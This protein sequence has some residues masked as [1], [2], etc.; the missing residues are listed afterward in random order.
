MTKK[1]LLE[2]LGLGLMLAPVLGG[3]GAP[4]AEL[5]LSE[6]DH[7]SASSVYTSLEP[8]DCKLREDTDEGPFTLHECQGVGDYSLH[9]SDADLRQSV[10][11]RFP[12]GHYD[13]PSNT[14]GGFS[15]VGPKAEWRV[16]SRR[17]PYALIFRHKLTDNDG[18]I[19]GKSRQVLAVTKLDGLGS[20]L[21]RLVDANDGEANVL[22]RRVADE[23]RDKP[24]PG[25]AT[26]TESIY[27]SL[28]AADCKLV[29]EGDEPAF[30]IQRCKGLA[31]Y[32]LVVEDFDARQSVTVVAPDGEV[33]LDLAASVGGGFSEVGTKAE[34]RRAKGAGA[35]HALI[36]RYIVTMPDGSKRPYLAVSKLAGKGSCLTKVLDAGK[37]P[38]ANE[39]A[40]RAADDAAASACPTDAPR[41][42]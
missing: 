20:C 1:A 4:D 34:W 33:P 2:T 21:V 36:F 24:C 37:A 19:E 8:K 29:E 41:P 38:D 6:Y 32:D 40:R 15:E 13:V 42:E 25:A 27:T 9:V 14:L 10:S 26:G 18:S 28:D 16:D 5:D 39:L 22:A 3:C 12:G 30:S 11:V 23:S 7:T 31:P 17:K 35:P